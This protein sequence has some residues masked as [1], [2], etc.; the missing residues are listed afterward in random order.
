MG[1]LE[2]MRL[3]Q[4]IDRARFE[5]REPDLDNLPPLS[6]TIDYGDVPANT[7]FEDVVPIEVLEK[8]EEIRQAVVEAYE[9]GAP[10]SVIEVI[11]DGGEVT[12]DEI[13]HGLI[14]DDG[15]VYLTEEDAALGAA[16]R[17]ELEAVS[18]TPIAD[19]IETPQEQE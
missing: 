11:A 15:T 5:G 9:A 8:Q 2:D 6:G 4:E 16:A 7:V 18:D 13:K 14:S 3:Q 19:S 1:L 12:E 17:E 10:D